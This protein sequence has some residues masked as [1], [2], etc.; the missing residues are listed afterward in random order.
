M[1]KVL[2]SAVL[3][4][5]LASSAMA[6]NDNANTNNISK[7]ISQLEKELKSLKKE[8]K[9]TKQIAITNQN[10]LDPIVSNN[11]LY[12]GL[13]IQSNYDFIDYKLTNGDTKTNNVFSNEVEIR[14]KARPANNLKATITL[15]AYNIWGM[16]A[17]NNINVLG[18]DNSNQ[19]ASETPD[20]TILRVKEAFFNY[21]FGPDGGY[22]ISF[23]RRP[24]THGFPA[25][26]RSN[27]YPGSPLAHLTNLEFDGF[28]FAIGNQVLSRFSDTLGNLG[29]RIKFC[30][31][32]AY[33]PNT[34]KFSQYPYTKGNN[35]LKI[36]DF[37]GAIIVPYDDGQYSLT[38]EFIYA[39]NVWG[40]YDKNKDG[41]P[42]TIDNSG[43]YLGYDLDLKTNG[44][45]NGINDF[46]DMTT[47][48]I[49]FAQSKTI[50]N[51]NGELGNTNS[52]LGWSIWVGADMPGI[53]DQ[54][55]DR[56]GI[57]YIHGSKYWRSMTYGED[58]LIGSIAA[59]RGDAVDVYYHHYL[60]DNLFVSLRG[61]L[62]KYDY[63]GSN[64]FFGDDGTPRK[65]E[66]VPSA[67]KNAMNIRASITYKF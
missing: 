3:V 38:T 44:I 26:L 36:N 8:V 61:T 35:Q 16:N 22:M 1:K 21:T 62:V 32:R 47:A 12:F 28:S 54:D 7:K 45:G 43:N 29:A 59:T 56:M 19:F 33:S 48:W 58:T 39:W 14:G 10:T 27:E 60:E 64:A 20:D 15:S 66:D 6:A 5:G 9:E 30:G 46:L 18:Y 2:L 24:A 42:E 31:G 52:K 65:V 67:V 53:F 34:G 51:K 25:Y 37:L 49:D 63:T 50:P 17:N 40:L 11:H 41:I 23:G 4:M 13:R 55:S 57:S